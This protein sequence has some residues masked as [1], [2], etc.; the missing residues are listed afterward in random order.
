MLLFR[1]TG[2]FRN[3]VKVIR[4]FLFPL[5][6]RKK[7]KDLGSEDERKNDAS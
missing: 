2:L 7:V 3:H 6:M 4:A 5:R 1:N